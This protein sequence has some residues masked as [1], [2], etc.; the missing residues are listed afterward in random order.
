MA[1]GYYEGMG[2]AN[3]EK[4]MKISDQAMEESKKKLEEITKTADGKNIDELLSTPRK[5]K[6][7]TKEFGATKVA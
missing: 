1:K 2:S 4:M 6:P 3:I 5:Y 7:L